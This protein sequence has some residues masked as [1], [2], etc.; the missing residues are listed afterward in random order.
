MTTPALRGVSAPRGLLCE[1]GVCG[2]WALTTYRRCE[3]RCVYCITGAQGVS[4]PLVAKSRMPTV[5]RDALQPLDGDDPIRVGAI[6]DAYPAVEDRYGVTRAALEV[7]VAERRHFNVITKGTGVF[8]DRDLLIEAKAHVTVSLCTVDEHALT[9]LDP[10]APS[11]AERLAL[12]SALAESGIS[13]SVSVAPWI[14]G[15]TDVAALIARVPDGIRVCVA[16]LN[17]VD[18]EVAKGYGRRF[19]QRAVNEAYLEEFERVGSQPLLVWLRPVR[20]D[21]SEPLTSPFT[22][23]RCEPVPAPA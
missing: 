14:P 2:G 13:L 17:V 4:T 20:I 11:A 22:Q 9:R 12:M 18:R 16:P 6:C 10:R 21:A 19:S 7:L 5:L 15:I 3:F 23:L 1:I 8:R